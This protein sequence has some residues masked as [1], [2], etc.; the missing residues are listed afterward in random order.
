M[1]KSVS[2]KSREKRAK[3]DYCREKHGLGYHWNKTLQECVVVPGLSSAM[4]EVR[5]NKA[6]NEAAHANQQKNTQVNQGKNTP[7]PAPAQSPKNT[8]LQT[9]K[10]SSKANAAIQ[11]EVKKRAK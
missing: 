9:V 7:A 6:K 10:S 3:D 5:D 1:E 2:Q 11:A 8:G 4:A